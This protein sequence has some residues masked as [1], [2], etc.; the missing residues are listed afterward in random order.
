MCGA[1]TANAKFGGS[2]PK[3]LSVDAMMQP[4]KKEAA[5]FAAA[6]AAQQF[7]NY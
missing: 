7:Y 2:S 3:E 5:A 1:H 4:P 6:A